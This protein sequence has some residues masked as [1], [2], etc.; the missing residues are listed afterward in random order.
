MEEIKKMSNA[1][2]K[3]LKDYNLQ[4]I[5]IGF[6][7]T[8]TDSMLADGFLKDIPIVSTIVGLSKGTVRIT[9]LLFLK[10]I[11]SFL[12]EQENISKK[13]RKE[14]IDKIDSSEK[15]RV[16]VGEK[17]LYIIDKCDDYES[18]QYI[19]KLFAG[20]IN[21]EIDYPDFLRASK[22]IEKIY[23]G[24]LKKFID[25]GRTE[26][27]TTELIEYEGTGLYEIYNDEMELRY[28]DNI[29]R[30]NEYM[31]HGGDP[32]GIITEMGKKIRKVL[33]NKK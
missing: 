31:L 18:S 17:L 33:K 23:I 12:Y 10:K 7:E 2:E 24:D 13:D 26:L 8:I 6:A 3:T 28:N 29:E 32:I 22:I 21:N 14:M 19:S 9:D 5:S 4:N 11:V 16:K 30:N 15:Y 25:D 20:F 1:F 27:E